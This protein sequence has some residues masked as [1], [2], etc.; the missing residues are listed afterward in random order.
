MLANINKNNEDTPNEY[1]ANGVPP[2]G[3]PFD[4]NAYALNLQDCGGYLDGCAL[5]G[6]NDGR[7]LDDSN[8]SAC[9][10]LV[11][12]C[13]SHPNVEVISFVWDDIDVSSASGSMH[14]LPNCF[15]A[16]GSA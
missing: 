3:I 5:T 14:L 6:Y 7:R 16:D 4:E 8:P 1:L 10:H 9:G 11:N 15:R 2:S 12:H 13:Y